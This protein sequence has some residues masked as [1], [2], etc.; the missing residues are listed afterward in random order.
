MPGQSFR[1]MGQEMDHRSIISVSSPVP[2]PPKALDSLGSKGLLSPEK[3]GFQ[4]S[5][6][7]NERS[8]T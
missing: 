7:P 3:S 5:V 8:S 4:I 1:T 2:P 6:P